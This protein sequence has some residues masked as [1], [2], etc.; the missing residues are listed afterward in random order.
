MT[1]YYPDISS[2]Q[3]GIN[4]AGWHAVA[5]KATQG[6]GYTDPYWGTFRTRAASAGAYFFGYHFLEE[7]NGSGQADHYFAVAGKTP[8]MID[9]EPTTGSNP[10]LGDAEAFCDRL[11]SHGCACNMVYLPRWYWGNL[12]SPS[13][14]GLT[15]RKLHLVS[16]DYVGYNDSGPGWSPYG[17]MAPA[18]WQYTSTLSTGG[19][20]Q[21][22]CNAYKGTFAQLAAMVG[23]TPPPPA[24][25]KP[26]PPPP[27]GDVVVP[28]VQGKT[29]GNAHN[30]LVAA[31]LVP[32]APAGQLASQI[33]Q[34]TSPGPGADAKAG[35][36]VSIAASNPP[37][38]QLNATGGWV[39]L[40]QIDLNRVNSG[41]KVDGDF[42]PATQAAVEHFQGT[43]GLSVDGIAGPDTW[44]RLGAL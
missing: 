17:G 29:A 13:L 3:A 34:N 39:Q 30:A 18:V 38:L 20:S 41:L 27:A 36:S 35:S 1:V 44:G 22:D 24:P 8:C 23:G 40:M 21:V 9:F 6:T 28:D 19:C 14:S 16:S 33:C 42:G 43:H 32:T 12:G 25:P 5:V 2:F 26:A 11:R 31:H 4:L 15:G 10:Q 7:G 37:V